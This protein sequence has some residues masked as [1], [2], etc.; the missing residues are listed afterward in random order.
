MTKTE[1]PKWA[2]IINPVAGNGNSLIAEQELQ[3]QLKQRNLSAKIVKTQYYGH[4]SQLAKELADQGFTNIIAVG[5]DGTL[6]EMARALIDYPQCTLGIIPAGTGNDFA[7]ILGMSV[8]FD[9]NDWDI[10][11]ESNTHSTDVGRCNGNYFFNGMGLGFDAQVA[12]ENY[13]P[14]GKIKESHRGSYIWHILKNLLFFKAQKMMLT[15]TGENKEEVYFLNTIAIGRRFAG[16]FFLTPKAIAD[17]GLLDVC[18]VDKLNLLQRLSI[19]LKVP[20]GTHLSHPKVHYYQTKKIAIALDHKAA[21]HLDGELFFDTHFEI[22]ILPGKIN[23]IYNPNGN[24]YFSNP[25]D[26]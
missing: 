1:Q 26:N 2:F 19:L 3:K 14:S 18:M 21:Y 13:L 8:N 10:F 15:T 23:F 4:A 11:F 20:K 24:H 5:G 25:K 22:D 7:Q 6:N 16:D 17:D 9:Q 12:S